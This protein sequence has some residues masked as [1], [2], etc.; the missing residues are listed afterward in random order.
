[1]NKNLLSTILL[2]AFITVANAQL[3]NLNEIK[4]WVGTG[5]NSVGLTIDFGDSLRPSS[6]IWGVRFD[7]DSISGQEILDLVLAADPQLS[8]M[9]SGFVTELTYKDYEGIQ[10]VDF[11]QFW[12]TYTGDQGAWVSN[13]GNVS[14]LGDGQWFGASFVKLSNMIPPAIGVPA[15]QL[16]AEVPMN[17]IDDLIQWTGQGV[18]EVA[19]VIDF[20]APGGNSSFAWGYRFDTDSVSGQEIIDAIFAADSNLSGAVSGF[21]TDVFYKSFSGVTPTNFTQFWLS[22]TRSDTSAWVANNGNS[23]K[24]VNGQWFGLAFESSFPGLGIDPAVT[25]IVPIGGGTE[26]PVVITPSVV[27]IPMDDQQFV[28]WATGAVI[29]RGFIDISDTTAV[30][31]TFSLINPNRATFGVPQNATGPAEGTSTDV[32]S[33]GDR[34]VATLTFE[35]SLFDGSGADFAVF[36]NSFSDVNLELAIVS[37]SSD[38]INFFDFPFISNIQDTIQ[39]GS[40]DPIDPGKIIGLAG[41]HPQGIGTPFD[42][43]VLS[44]VA[45]TSVLDINNVTHI[46]ITDVVGSIDPAYATYDDLGNAVNEPFPTAFGSGGFDLDAVGVIHQNPVSGLDLT[47]SNE[48]SVFPNPASDVLT[49]EMDGFVSYK[50]LT[51]LGYEVI[52]GNEKLI[53]LEEL[54]S[55]NYLLQVQSEEKVLTT[56]LMIQ[57]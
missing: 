22:S 10:P 23:T 50:V 53:T 27:G 31:T 36:E 45:D 24:I 51:A 48:L 30:D 28:A 4:A 16:P 55:G 1:M 2:A 56:P 14:N 17:K 54:K 9:A 7:T 38:G 37:V 20:K 15:D 52:S 25:A 12:L 6:F 19:L 32:V 40:F 42:L 21:V 18:N 33:L 26:P 57:K 41:I 43:S 35:A 47:A 34:G 49:I 29:Q 11:S 39:V 5:V 44:A 13:A 46:R 3:N 8:G